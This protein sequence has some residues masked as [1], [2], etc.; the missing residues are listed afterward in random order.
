MW[1]ETDPHRRRKLVS[2]IVTDDARYLDP[3]M[4]GNGAEEITGFLEAAA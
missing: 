1:N 3:I 4:S 2:E